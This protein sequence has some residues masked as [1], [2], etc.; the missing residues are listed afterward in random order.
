MDCCVSCTF[1]RLWIVVFEHWPTNTCFTFWFFVLLTRQSAIA[2]M[3]ILLL[4][5]E[6]F[7]RWD[8]D[9]ETNEICNWLWKNP[10]CLQLCN[11]YLQC[12]VLNLTGLRTLPVLFFFF[13][14]SQEC[15]IYWDGAFVCYFF[16]MGFPEAPRIV[17]GIHSFLCLANHYQ[18]PTGK[19]V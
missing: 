13:F 10:P 9:W 1:W 16:A 2:G 17:S 19:Q 4:M 12:L 8:W 3:L 11:E 15:D 7:H 6:W 5:I 14:F 18:V